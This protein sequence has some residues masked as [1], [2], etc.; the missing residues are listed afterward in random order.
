[1]LS[2]ISTLEKERTRIA[3]DLHDELGPVLSTIK[4][5]IDSVQ[6][7]DAEETKQL[8]KASNQVDGLVSRLREI[9][10]DLIPASLLRKGL[11]PAVE[12]FAGEVSVSSSLTVD[13][14]HYALPPLQQQES[15]NIYRIIQEVTH[16]TLKHANASRLTI[17]I[18]Q[19]KND[20]QLK[21]VDN[22][23]GFNYEKALTTGSGLGLRNL[24][25]R[26]DMMGGSMLVE[27]KVGVGTA[28]LFIIPV[29]N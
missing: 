14:S 16:N 1:M 18:S 5:K 8:E 10:A 6:S 24:K 3:T 20:L 19:V 23:Q 15:I 25:S 29:K 9:A 22:G 21:C 26:T 27:S 28:Y 7:S 2:E 12:E 4:F 17:S 11:A 13:V